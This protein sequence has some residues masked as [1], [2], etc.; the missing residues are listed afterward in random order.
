M[1]V[2]VFLLATVATFALQ[3]VSGLTPSTVM[4]GDAATPERS[5]GQRGVGPGPAGRRAVPRLAR[6]LLRGDLGTSWL[7]G[8]S[9]SEQIGQRLEV[10][11]SVAGLALVIAMAP[12]PCSA[13]WP[14]CTAGSWFDRGGHGASRR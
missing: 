7:N 3:A 9:V 12:A 4:L 6:A 2:P 13:C 11:L 1:A 8:V 5:P 14:P 10:S